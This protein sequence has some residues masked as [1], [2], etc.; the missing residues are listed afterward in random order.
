MWFTWSR[1]LDPWKSKQEKDKSISVSSICQNEIVS[2]RVASAA[3]VY[4]KEKCASEGFW[5]YFL[6]L[7]LG[8]VSLRIIYKKKK[9]TKKT[10]FAQIQ[11]VL[12]K[13]GGVGG[14]GVLELFDAWVAVWLTNVIFFFFLCS[15][16]VLFF[17][18][19]IV[20]MLHTRK[21]S[22]TDLKKEK[23][24]IATLAPIFP[25]C[26]YSAGCRG[27]NMC[28]RSLRKKITVIHF[29]GVFFSILFVTCTATTFYYLTFL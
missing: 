13:R 15:V 19:V 24:K 29:F 14:R 27:S 11:S 2:S 20:Y 1:S 3:R 10:C 6:C 12:C 17:A 25:L 8:C 26:K 16:C 28:L 5:F 4:S 18:L 9:T 22:Y 23:E 21:M 7:H